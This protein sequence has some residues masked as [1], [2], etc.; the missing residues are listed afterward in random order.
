M[1]QP[2]DLPTALSGQVS[3]AGD[4]FW[5]RGGTYALG[6]V[7]TTIEG[8]AGRPITFRQNPGEKARV[9]GSIS[10][11]NSSGYVILRDFEV[12]SSDTNRASSQIGVGFNVTDIQIIP[13]I[14]S[15][16]PNLSFINLIVHDQTRH[17][18]YISRT[19]TNNL[20]YGCIVYNN[21]W[22]SRDNA[23]G[24][25]L[26][27]QGISGTTE[28]ADNVVLNNSGASMHSY[29]DTAGSRLAGITLDGNVAFGAGAIQNMRPYRD[30]IVGVDAPAV[31]ADRM[32]L[33]NNMGYVPQGSGDPEEVEIGR[34]A[35]NGSV[36]VLNNYLPQGFWMKNWSNATVTGNLF[37]AQRGYAVRLE[38]Q[39]S[40]LQAFWDQNTY[41]HSTT[42]R[43]FLRNSTEYDF[44]G[45]RNATG[46]DQSSTFSIGRPG[47][48]KVFVRPN[49][50]EAGRGN[51]IVYNW[52]NLNS[53]GVDVS[54][55]L[56]PGAAYEV[57]NAQDFLAAPV[58]SGVYD[59]RPLQLPMTGLTVAVPNGPLLTP[60]PTGPTFNVFV[61]LS[62]SVRL[63]VVSVDGKPEVSWPTNAGTWVLQF[64]SSVTREWTDYPNGPTI[65]AGDYVVRDSLPGDS[66]FY[67]LRTPR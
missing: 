24:H 38:Q 3:Q 12:Y 64:S 27:V 4:T 67:R 25:G 18:I 9:N 30:W 19:A 41:W 2:Y 44:S 52:E 37:V 65:R 7:D 28:V 34:Q 21:G 36:S 35:A 53:V 43:D 51:I 23:E 46:F 5:L 33:K 31:S 16:V 61:L 60:P 62:R 20:V 6:H 58:L 63:N 56:A 48:T 13:G 29:E 66:R 42:G 39:Q 55:V 45:W 54:S 50:Y 57:R 10:F 22:V 32:M 26:H 17:G 49:R 1:E 8:A 40:S 47:G 59:G 14:A 11:F 15:F